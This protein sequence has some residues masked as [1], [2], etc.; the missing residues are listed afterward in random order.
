MIENLGRL[1]KRHLVLFVAMRDAELE[2]IMLSEP[3]QVNDMTRSVIAHS[4][5]TEKE[6]VLNRLSRLGAEIIN[7]PAPFR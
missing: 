5:I 2:S 6:L 7:A 4:L 3:K 1:M